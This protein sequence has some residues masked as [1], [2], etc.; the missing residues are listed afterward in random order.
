MADA[1]LQWA[2]KG[3]PIPKQ[4]WHSPL[5]SPHYQWLP[6]NLTFQ[7]DGTVRFTSYINNLHPTKYPDIYRAIERL[8]DVAIPAWD[9]CLVENSR[10]AGSQRLPGRNEPRFAPYDYWV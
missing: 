1:V 3:D 2:G 10:N 6:A 9:Q 8:V 7:E 5:L 4:D